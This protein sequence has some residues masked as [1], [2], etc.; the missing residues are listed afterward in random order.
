MAKSLEEQITGRCRH[1]TGIMSKECKAGIEYSSFGKIMMN[2]P[3]LSGSVMKCPSASFPT[4]EEAK[5][6]VAKIQDHSSKALFLM[7]AAKDQYIK[8]KKPV[9]A[10]N[11]PN[12][13]QLARYQ[14]MPSNGHFW[15]ACNTCKLRL[16][17]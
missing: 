6:E 10:F 4:P 17:E 5:A 12:C 14:R 3:C 7:T 9:D 15:V 8:S 11:C 13:N 2:I 16:N 1:F